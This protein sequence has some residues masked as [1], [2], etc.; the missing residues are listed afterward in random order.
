MVT[1]GLLLEERVGRSRTVWANRDSAL[2]EP[3]SLLVALTYGPRPV[4]ERPLAEV[5]GVDR[6]LIYGSWAARY[7]GETGATPNDVD[8]LVLGNPDRD[9]LFDAADQARRLLHRDVSIRSVRQPLWDEP[10]SV[11]P[12]LQHVKSR[13]V[14]EQG[15]PA[16]ASR[17]RVQRRCCQYVS[18]LIQFTGGTR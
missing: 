16:T 14:V 2:F 3:L 13:P 5:D 4:L 8:V 10:A 11:D 9:E 12:F 7:R 18:E 1:S 17:P 6:A 15:A